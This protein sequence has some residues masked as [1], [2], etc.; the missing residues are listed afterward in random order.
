MAE[1]AAWAGRGDRVA[2]VDSNE[3]AEGG[4]GMN[5]GA[6]WTMVAS[7][8]GTAGL[9]AFARHAEAQASVGEWAQRTPWG[10]LDLQGEW[11][12]EGEYGVP[13]ERPAEFGTR[14][15]LTDEEYAKRLADV[16][17][18]DERDLRSVDVSSGTVEGPNAPIPHWREY[19]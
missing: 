9:A 5:V 15:F 12:S 2:T 14:E 1:R 16:Q 7:V 4:G 3:I 11:T 18:R 6:V 17:E 10:D 13:L 19:E 8:L